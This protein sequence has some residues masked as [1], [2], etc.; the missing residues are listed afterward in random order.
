[1]FSCFIIAIVDQKLKDLCPCD[2]IKLIP[3]GLSFKGTLVKIH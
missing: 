2:A 3:V 1:M